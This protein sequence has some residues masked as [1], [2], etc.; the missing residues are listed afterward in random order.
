MCALF[1]LPVLTCLI[2]CSLCAACDNPAL[3]VVF[4]SGFP[5]LP[6]DCHLYRIEWCNYGQGEDLLLW[7]FLELLHDQL[8]SFPSFEFLNLHWSAMCLR[9]PLLRPL[10][11]IA[12]WG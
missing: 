6:G 8:H 5:S 12:F 2:A 10:H 1:L 9:N 3:T 4:V 11:S 7:W